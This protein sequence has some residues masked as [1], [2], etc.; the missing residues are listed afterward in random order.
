MKYATLGLILGVLAM[1]GCVTTGFRAG[2]PDGA[3]DVIAHRGASAYAPENTLAAFKLAR[4]LNADW[5][6]LDCTLRMC[7]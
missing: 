4:E 2:A 6:E 1:I 5:F 3:I 7:K